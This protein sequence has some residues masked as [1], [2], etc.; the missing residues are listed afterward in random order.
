MPSLTRFLDNNP[1]L[2]TI[3]PPCASATVTTLLL[4]FAGIGFLIAAL[5]FTGARRERASW[6]RCA[7]QVA[8]LSLILGW[9]LLIGIRVWLFF[10][11]DGYVPQSFL[12]SVIELSW[13]ALGFAVVTASLHFAVWKFL[14]NHR[15][16]HGCLALLIGINGV[17]ATA[18]LLGSLRMLTALDLPNASQ[19]TI[20]DLYNFAL[21]PSPLVA[22]TALLV[23][24]CLAMPASAAAVWLCARRNRDNFGRDY[25]NT[26]LPWCCRWALV[27]W[28]ITTILSA[29]VVAGEAV[30]LNAAAPIAPSPAE[31]ALWAL[32]VV[33]SIV[34]CVIYGLAARSA[35]PMR[36]EGA[37]WVALLCCMPAAAFLS[38]DATSFL[39]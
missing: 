28:I 39:F 9:I 14:E 35:T 6:F 30:G 32:R 38:Y 4:A 20:A 3:L 16:L 26:M 12:G 36:F 29:L 11:S 31:I 10:N 18:A 33:P 5:E 8:V 19:L 15:V 21:V 17:T 2:S 1:A 24:L 13:G 22:A 25:Y 37:L 7:K 34:A 27:L 23:P